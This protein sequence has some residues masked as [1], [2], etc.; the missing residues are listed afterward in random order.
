[1]FV[2]GRV[3][4]EIKNEMARVCLART[5]T[6]EKG[7]D[8]EDHIIEALPYPQWQACYRDA[9]IELDHDKLKDRVRQAESAIVDRLQT[10]A[11]SRESLMER[12]AIADALANLRCLKRETFGVSNCR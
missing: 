5:Q 7:D 11:P 8:M 1:M 3:T 2:G 10:L 12:Q 4:K 6:F 9:L